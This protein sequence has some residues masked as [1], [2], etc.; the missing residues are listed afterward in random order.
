MS[1]I[2]KYGLPER[3]DVADK[4][5]TTTNATVL[6]SYVFVFQ[7]SISNYWVKWSLLLSLVF[8]IASIALFIW[9]GQRYP[10]RIR[11]YNQKQEKTVKKY[12]HR[13]AVFMED[14]L[15]PLT[16]LRVRNEIQTRLLSTKSKEEF[17]EVLKEIKHSVEAVDSNKGL[18]QEDEAVAF[19]V[20]S[21]IGQLSNESR[22]Q[23]REA[24]RR[25]LKERYSKVKLL[26]D[27]LALKT[28]RH[29]FVS[30]SIFG[31]TSVF[32]Q[33]LAQ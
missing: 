14:I 2:E 17:E 33:L 4:Y 12:S 5:L 20:E 1:N 31:L 22:E 6:I 24:F 18:G 21:F 23:W 13:I 7:L 15:K 25:P 8:F 32:I 10:K 11:I 3:V 30:A 26:I 16:Q 9:H 27:I 28:R 29:I 19:V